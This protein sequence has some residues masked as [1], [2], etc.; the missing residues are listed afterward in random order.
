[1]SEWGNPAEVILCHRPAEYIGRGEPTRGIETSKYPQEQKSTEIP[2]VVASERGIAQTE[3]MQA[4]RRC[5]F[6]VV[7]PFGERGST[8]GKLQNLSLAEPS[9]KSGHSR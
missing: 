7:G 9:G 4:Y 6:G 5:V 1:M 2:L 3:R 8:P